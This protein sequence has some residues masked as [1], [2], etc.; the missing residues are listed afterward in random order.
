MFLTGQ[1]QFHVMGRG[2]LRAGLLG[3]VHHFDDCELK[4]LLSITLKKGF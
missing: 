1:D 3:F 4:S 2:N